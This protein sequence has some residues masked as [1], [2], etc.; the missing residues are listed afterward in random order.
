MPAF[1]TWKTVPN[2]A[3]AVSSVSS[4]NCSGAAG[5]KRARLH[6]IYGVDG[7]FQKTRGNPLFFLWLQLTE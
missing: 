6:I 3:A 1:S 7:F 2:I 4:P 5:L